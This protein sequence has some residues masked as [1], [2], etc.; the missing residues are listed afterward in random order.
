METP[1]RHLNEYFVSFTAT[2]NSK[3]KLLF[4][5]L[6]SSLFHLKPY[7]LLQVVN[8]ETKNSILLVLDV[9]VALASAYEKL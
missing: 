9:Q 6:S 2:A 7:L 3:L 5:S 1:K 4:W 8:F